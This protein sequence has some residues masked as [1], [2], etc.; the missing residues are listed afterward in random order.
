MSIFL[1]FLAKLA[2]L[3]LVAFGGVNALL[4]TIFNIA[5]NQEHWIDAQ[6][7]SDYS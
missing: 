2:A 6:T 1:G 5:V 3:S 7:F 4:P